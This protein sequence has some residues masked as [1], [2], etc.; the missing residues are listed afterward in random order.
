MRKKRKTEFKRKYVDVHSHI[1]PRVDDGAVSMEQSISMLRIAVAEGT[2]VI[3]ATP[4]N[5]PG[6][7]N[8]SHNQLKQQLEALRQRAAEEQ[9]SV[10]IREG[11]EYFYREWVLELLEKQQAVTY[12]STDCILI[13]FDPCTEKKYINNAVYEILSRGYRP[14]LAHVERYVQLMQGNYDCL[15]ELRKVGAL[16]QINCSSVTGDNGR[17]AKRDTRRLLKL[18]MVDLVGTDA[19]SDGHRAPRMNRCAEI[20]ENKYGEDYAE[21]LLRAEALGKKQ[22]DENEV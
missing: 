3:Y 8:L 12:Q 20:L 18:R 22:Q 11:T 21:S 5:M 6:K 16:I 14:V 17:K 15:K 9:I 7:G 4:H 2:G 1:L 10:Q 13:E 19:H